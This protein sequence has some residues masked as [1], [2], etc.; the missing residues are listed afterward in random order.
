MSDFE[1]HFEQHFFEVDDFFDL[2]DEWK[3]Q[4][5][6]EL[7]AAKSDPER[8][9]F[10]QYPPEKPKMAIGE[11]VASQ[12]FNVPIIGSQ[13]EWEEA[14]D[15]D[16]AM[17]RS[18]SSDDY[19][20]MSGIMSS[21]VLGKYDRH[22]PDDSDPE[23]FR[24]RFWGLVREGLRSGELSPDE[25]MKLFVWGETAIHTQEQASR[26]RVPL[27]LSYGTSTS[28]WRYVPGTNIRM[29]RDPNVE[30]KYF[31]GVTPDEGFVAGYEV[32]G[33][34]LSSTIDQERA[35]SPIDVAKLV[36]FYERIRALP[37]FDTT[38]APLLEIQQDENG[39]L[40][41]LQYFRTGH[42]VELT[43][44][45]DLPEGENVIR[46]TDVRGV[47][48]PDGER[49]RLYISPNFYTTRMDKQGFY[50]DMLYHQGLL[51][52]YLCSVGRVA[53]H[54]VYI[55]MKDNHFNSSPVFRPQ[56]GMGL[57]DLKGGVD[58]ARMLVNVTRDR[59]H[60][61]DTNAYINTVVTS[62]GREATIESDWELHEEAN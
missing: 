8:D 44:P 51:E 45:F 42:K 10:Y 34:S 30:Q 24:N 17:I 6:R 54:E 56:V 43:E 13:E 2:E 61:H 19:A 53:V 49:M 62:N 50:F 1:R 55:S 40:H 3:Q 16:L 58:Q 7:D 29:F 35:S 37:L 21:K 26:A 27:S 28:L 20:G 57:M 4:L 36:D 22:R 5:N 25:Y 31:L 18:E 9:F 41:F 33:D 32:E 15:S 11:Y 23:R 48:S 47:T 60:E 14:F 38:Q 46:A 12:G 39:E 52:Q 59:F